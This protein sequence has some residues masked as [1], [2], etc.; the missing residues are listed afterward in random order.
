MSDENP[1]LMESLK[2][3][4]ST[5]TD[6]ISTRLELLGNEWEEERLH[7]TQMLLI[8]LFTL[9]CFGT[10]VLF[11]SLFLLVLFWDDHR[12]AVVGALSTFF[13]ALGVVMALV[14]RRKARAKPKLF[15][16]S[17]AELSKDK[18]QLEINNE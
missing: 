15:S 10:G 17:L 6:I 7:L 2:R 1:G 3:L 9:F 5:L 13:F 11:L 4:L 16:A 14:M 8:S 18:A 12:L